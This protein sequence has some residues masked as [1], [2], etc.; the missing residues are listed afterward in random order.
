MTTRA[1]TGKS[2]AVRERLL[3][4]ALELVAEV[5]WGAVSTRVL[6]ERAGV[7]PGLVH[8]YFT[9]VHALLQEA[10]IGTLRELMSGVEST[11]QACPSP[12]DAIAVLV[13]LLDQYDGRDPMSLVASE[14]FLA[15]T[16]DPDLH[17]ELQT[18][19]TQ[20]NSTLSAW[21]EEHHVAD[22]VA[23]ASVVAATVDG[24][25]LHRPMNPKLTAAAVL[26][27]VSRLVTTAS[28]D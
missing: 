16:R 5:G 12:A 10:T 18:L 11:L 4:A 21:L 28:G 7:A 25:M 22:P 15:A 20:F 2:P 19:F 14:T 24:L 23:T 6:A 27:I 17:A 26:P 8:Y 13:G 9:S 3:E 1:T